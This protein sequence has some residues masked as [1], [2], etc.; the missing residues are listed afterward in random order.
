MTKPPTASLAHRATIQP[1]PACPN[2]VK[3][4]YGYACRCT[5]T[6]CGSFELPTAPRGSALV[7]KSVYERGFFMNTTVP[8]IRSRPSATPQKDD[9]FSF[10]KKAT[11][12]ISA[13]NASSGH[14]IDGFGSAFTDAMAYN[15]ESLDDA[16][17]STFILSHF[18][19]KGIGYTM[20]RVPMGA[21]DFSRMDYVL[22][23]RTDDFTL[24]SFCLRD[25]SAAEVPCGTDYKLNPILDAQAA[26]RRDNHPELKL[27]V[28]MWSPPL[29]MKEQRMQCDAIGGV[30][31]CR[32]NESAE[33]LVQCM[34]T[35]A[36][37]CDDNPIKH[38]CPQ[39]DG[40]IFAD[41]QY[42]GPGTGHNT[43]EWAEGMIVHNADGNCYYSGMLSANHSR[44]QALADLYVR[45][46]TA[47]KER[48][49]PVWGL[50]VQN[51]PLTQTGLWNGMFYTAELQAAFVKDAL[52]PTLRASYPDVKLMIH[53]DATNELESFAAA[54]LNDAEA[55]EYVDGVGFH[56]YT[57]FEGLYENDK[58][59]QALGPI[60]ELLNI[61]QVG[62]GAQVR[63][64]GQ[65]F[66][67][68]FFL[69]TEA[70]NGFALGT[71]FVG[72]RPGEWGYGYS[73]SH[74]IMWQL[75]NGAT[76]W[77]DWNML[78]DMNGGPN[79]NGNQVDAPTLVEDSATLIQN[80]SL[81]HMAHFSRFVPPGSRLLKQ[82]AVSCK[83]DS[84][85]YC[86]NVVAFIT[87]IDAT[88]TPNSLVFVL[89]NDEITAVPNYADG[90]GVLAYD[91]L[92]KGQ[93]S[94]NIGLRTTKE[95]Y[96]T[97]GCDNVG[98]VEGVLEW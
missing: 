53:D 89:T 21:S 72:A 70:C 88:S 91:E 17:R 44:Q 75:K 10:P 68:K 83:L 41:P 25:D 80:P 61:P 24:S 35:V 19:S 29:W 98:W 92:A 50:T 77:V 94:L 2:P 37:P 62:G 33:Q 16:T 5:P 9:A 45:F 31:R 39:S 78:L 23:N 90:A 14:P 12:Q 51:E 40:S 79:H 57:H 66:P 30:A 55:A 74:D 46:L 54:V 15:F 13:A 56:W 63:T 58:G 59:K 81:F 84:S 64:V 48:G 67:D 47:Y 3:V 32:A 8:V 71:S 27:Y 34:A 96:Y 85:A 38:R 7:I 82:T 20:G 73:Y 6:S 65:A 52:G 69:M 4:A 87:P 95:V 36:S 93:G 49:V 42:L 43:R 97:V 86:E 1:T 18:G 26:L 60:S 22:T 28:S 11:M 76:G